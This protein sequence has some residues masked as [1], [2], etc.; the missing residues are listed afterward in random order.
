MSSFRNEGSNDSYVVHRHA[1]LDHHP[2]NRAVGARAGGEDIHGPDHIGL[3]GRPGRPAGA[4]EDGA[5]D[6]GVELK[7]ADQLGQERL[8]GVGMNE[9]GPLEADAGIDDIDPEDRLH[10]GRAARAAS[11]DDRR[12][13]PRHR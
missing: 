9:L 13:S 6:N 10:T 2:L 11:R 12:G 1:R 8:A 7:L 5:V 3:V 4:G